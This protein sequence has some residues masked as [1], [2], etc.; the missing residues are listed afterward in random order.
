MSVANWPLETK[1][2]NLPALP[3]K[4]VQVR[5]RNS[6]IKTG[7]RSEF[8]IIIIYHVRTTANVAVM[9]AIVTIMIAQYTFQ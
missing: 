8:I 9:C 7:K 1:T 6:H 5:C 3:Y 2:K 4:Y